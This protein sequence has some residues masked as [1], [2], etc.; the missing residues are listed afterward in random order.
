M[1]IVSLP[2]DHHTLFL[3]HMPLYQPM[4]YLVSSLT[5]T[6]S[7]ANGIPAPLPACV[8]K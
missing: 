5:Y 8:G 1:S 4:P 3:S 7:P 6:A 2:T